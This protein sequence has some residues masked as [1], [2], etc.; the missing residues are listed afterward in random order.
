MHIGLRSSTLKGLRRV[1]AFWHSS[2][3]LEQLVALHSGLVMNKWKHYFE[4]YDWHF[5][6]FRERE[7]TLLE[8]GVAGGGSL[9]VWRKY[10]GPNAR[11]FGLD[12]NSECKRFE[13]PGTQIFV[14]SQGDPKFLEHLAHEIGPIDILIDDGS[15]AY[16]DQ[17]TTFHALFKHVRKDGLYVC[18]DLCSSYWAEEYHGGICRSGTYVEFLKGLIDELNAWFWRENVEAESN[19][20]AR[21][22]HGM[23]FYPTLVVIEKR[24]MEK[25]LI[26]PVGRTSAVERQLQPKNMD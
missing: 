2:T 20:F 18:E 15:H 26:T 4:I 23:Y 17:L 21:C 25:P 12:I 13:S 19:G 9:Q 10:F 7:I 11:I 1:R 24:P 22:V 6:R 16:N 3:E 14:G 5:T 8:I